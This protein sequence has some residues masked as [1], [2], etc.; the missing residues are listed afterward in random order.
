MALPSTKTTI[1][2]VTRSPAWER[3]VEITWGM[4]TQV[5]TSRAGLEQR[6]QQ[7]GRVTIGMKYEAVMNGES[8]RAREA[9][10]AFEVRAALVVPVWP[11]KAVTASVMFEN[12]VEIS[13]LP[14]MDLFAPGDYV[15]LYDPTLGG[16]FRL[17]ASVESV[18]LTFEEDEAAID[19]P[20][21]ST[22]YP[23][24]LF[25][26]A[27]GEANSERLSDESIAEMFDL[28]TL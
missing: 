12:E 17:I 28:F 1:L 14:T 9:R 26:R 5:F 6:T 27:N 19:F 16:Q 22:I 4:V 20:E 3:D 13:T 18:F 10:I 8:A 15:F 7:R 25:T 23:C 2:F 21:G 11:F 24:R